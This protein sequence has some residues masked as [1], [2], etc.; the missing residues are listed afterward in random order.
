M[1]R[2]AALALIFILASGVSLAHDLPGL[3]EEESVLDEAGLKA[4]AKIEQ[5]EA[6][7]EARIAAA[8]GDLTGLEGVVDTALAWKKSVVTGCFFGGEKETR[9]AITELANSWTIGTRLE[10]DFGPKGDRRTC[11]ASKPSDIR[12]GFAMAG[13]WSYVGA[14]SSIVP[15]ENPTLNLS[16]FGSTKSFSKA[17]AGVVLHE[18]GHALGFK[19][20]HQSPEASCDEEFDW[21]YLYTSL[22]WDKA[23]VDR[24]LKKLLVSSKTTLIATTFDEDS[25]MLYALGK[26]AFK[27][28][29]TAKCYIPRQNTEISAVDR[30]TIVRLYPPK[31]ANAPDQAPVMIDDEIAEAV[32]GIQ[33][34]VGKE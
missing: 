13:H 29:A 23:T 4:M 19:H 30:N 16:G 17:Q 25:V 34:V 28:W 14:S 7:I 2:L 20:E 1:K 11:D 8:G 26:K 5:Y 15:A 12:V 18:F 24:N 6:K 9:D 31:K 3:M 27:D 33:S 22:G 32:A 10:L 21:N